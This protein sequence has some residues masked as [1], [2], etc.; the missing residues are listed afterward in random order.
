MLNLF[1][2]AVD[3]VITPAYAQNWAPSNTTSMELPELIQRGLNLAVI[4]AGVVAVAFLIYNGIKY[5]TAGGDAGKA[6]DAQQGIAQAL[7]G[8]VVA[9]ASYVII[10]FVMRALGSELG[11]ITPQAM[12]VLTT[13]LS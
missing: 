1:K 7:I 3:L 12:L 2:K 5:I 11:D 4:I 13:V 6:K 9:V 10:S 8:L